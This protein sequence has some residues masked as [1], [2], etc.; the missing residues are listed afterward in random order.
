M[1]DE[2]LLLLGGPIENNKASDIVLRRIETAV[3]LLNSG[4]DLRIVV[5]GGETSKTSTLSEAQIMKNEL[6]S[7]GI[8]ENRIILEDKAMT[9]LQNFKNTASLL[10]KDASVSFITNKFHIW[11]CK[12]IM[13]KAGVN[14]TPVSAPNGAHSLLFRIRETF[15]RPFA[16]IGIIW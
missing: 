11:R 7:H 13:K 12:K 9:T 2:Y 3:K 5:S 6:I 4:K 15:L 10:G 8:D 1:K 14:Y 16:L